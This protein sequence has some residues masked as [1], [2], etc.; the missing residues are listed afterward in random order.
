MAI[1]AMDTWPS[2]TLRF[3]DRPAVAK[4]AL[5]AQTAATSYPVDPAM[6]GCV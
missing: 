3:S 5:R 4:P 1:A 2:A 6:L